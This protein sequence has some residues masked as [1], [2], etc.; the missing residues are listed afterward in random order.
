MGAKHRAHPWILSLLYPHRLKPGPAGGGKEQATTTPAALDPYAEL[1]PFSVTATTSGSTLIRPWEAATL[2]SECIL[3]P[4][5]ST[6]VDEVLPEKVDKE[7]KQV[8]EKPS[9]PSV[10]L[11]GNW[12]RTRGFYDNKAVLDRA[13]EADWKFHIKKP[14]SC[15]SGSHGPFARRCENTFQRSSPYFTTTRLLAPEMPFHG[16]SGATAYA[17]GRYSE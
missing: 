12:K 14:R 16:R 9:M 6:R 3:P 5:C 7:E 13:F 11:K 1:N 8:E 15:R 10:M 17:Q 4:L 2:W